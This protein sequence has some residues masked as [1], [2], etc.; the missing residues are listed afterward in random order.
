M[1]PSTFTYRSDN[2]FYFFLFAGLGYLYLRQRFIPIFLWFSCKIR[3]CFEITR[4]SPEF[5]CSGLIGFNTP[6]ELSIMSTPSWKY[7]LQKKYRWH[8]YFMVVFVLRTSV[9]ISRYILSVIL[10]I[11]HQAIHFI[12]S[13]FSAC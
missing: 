8:I 4:P 13:I 12:F 2:F 11:S 10:K 1:I 7:F 6:Q 9:N 5:S 3:T